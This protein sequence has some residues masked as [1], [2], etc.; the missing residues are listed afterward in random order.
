MKIIALDPGSEQTAYVLWDGTLRDFGIV[1]NERCLELLHY[2]G[3]RAR[4]GR[5]II[6]MIGHYGKGMPAGREVFDTCIWIG[7]F[8]EAFGAERT[9]TMLRATIKAHLCG[10]VKAKDANVRQ[11][12]IDRFGGPAAIRKGGPLYRVSSH[13][14]AALAVAVTWWDT[15]GKERAA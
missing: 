9:E 3:N 12:L 15:Q 13:V 5:C 7:R 11:A 2:C 8:T 4:V 14:W 6:E 10:S 1:P